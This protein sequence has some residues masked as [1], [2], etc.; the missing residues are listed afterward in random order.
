MLLADNWLLDG[1]V[2]LIAGLKHMKQTMEFLCKV[3]GATL[4]YF[5]A[6]FV[7]FHSVRPLK[8]LLASYV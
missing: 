6:S 1:R 4:H 8:S 7:L 5:L 2:S 3:N